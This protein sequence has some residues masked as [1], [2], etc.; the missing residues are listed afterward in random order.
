[1]QNTYKPAPKA[2]R[3]WR[4]WLLLTAPPLGF[5]LG[6]IAVFLPVA[7]LVAAFVCAAAMAAAFFVLL[8]KTAFYFELHINDGQIVLQKRLPFRKNHL[9]P[10]A[11]LCG[12]VLSQTPAMRLL[13]LCALEIRCGGF[14]A[15]CIGLGIEDGRHISAIMEGLK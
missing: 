2:L 1:M 10:K 3:L 11:A 12:M 9:I 5:L 7:A 6:I 14:G 13:G 8:P 15:R 4:L